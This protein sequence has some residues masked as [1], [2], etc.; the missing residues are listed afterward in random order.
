MEAAEYTLEIAHQAPSCSDPNPVSEVLKNAERAPISFMIASGGVLSGGYGDGGPGVCLD[1]GQTED[2]EVPS[3][4]GRG[5]ALHRHMPTYLNFLYNLTNTLLFKSEFKI[6]AFLATDL[7]K[8]KS[9]TNE[10]E[11]F[12]NLFEAIFGVRLFTRTSN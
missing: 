10:A 11:L 4:G 1:D 3:Q 6:D 2:E 7:L 5:D 9:R 12:N 8:F